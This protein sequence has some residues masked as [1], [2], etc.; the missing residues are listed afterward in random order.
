MKWLKYFL[1]FVVCASDFILIAAILTAVFGISHSLGTIIFFTILIA[2]T[3]KVWKETG[4]LSHWK[5]ETRQQ[6]YK[7]WD[8]VC[9][10]KTH[11][12]IRN[13]REVTII[14]SENS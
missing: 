5:K 11:I 14:D 9:D 7:N 12:E 13:G 2:G 8:D 6:F 1:Q 3:C 10:G 4:G